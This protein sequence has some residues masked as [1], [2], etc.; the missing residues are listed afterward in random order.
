MLMR[1]MMTVIERENMIEFSGMG[2]PIV[3]I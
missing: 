1:A 3:V 2:V